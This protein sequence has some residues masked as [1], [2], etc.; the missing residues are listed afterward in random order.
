MDFDDPIERRKW[1]A[2]LV[3][4]ARGHARRAGRPFELTT[5]FIETL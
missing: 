5:E 1:P 3:A 2:R 4:S